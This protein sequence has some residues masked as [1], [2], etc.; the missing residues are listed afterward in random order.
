M[1]AVLSEDLSEDL[2][3]EVPEDLSEEVPETLRAQ[4]D[5]A[6]ESISHSV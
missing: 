3:E 5:L 4:G 6:H 2:S 1:E